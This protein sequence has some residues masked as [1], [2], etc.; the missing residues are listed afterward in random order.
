MR[1]SLKDFN[2]LYKIIKRLYC[3]NRSTFDPL[4]LKTNPI[5]ASKPVLACL[6]YGTDVLANE[7]EYFNLTIQIVDK[8]TS[9]QIANI[10][11]NVS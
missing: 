4:S 5:T 11:W 8:Y 1:N 3:W 7:N 10:S 6:T 2:C 9:L